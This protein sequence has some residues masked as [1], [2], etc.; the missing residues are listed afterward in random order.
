M[1]D[2]HYSGT[3]A[4][5]NAALAGSLKIHAK[6]TYSTTEKLGYVTG[7]FKIDDDDSRV[8][9]SFSGTIDDGRLVGYL[10]GKA[11]GNHAKVLGNLSADFAGGTTSFSN[12][13]VGSSSS[14]AVLAIVAG[15][16]CKMPKPEKEE[17][18]ERE[19]K[20]EKY[21]GARGEITALSADSITVTG[22]KGAVTCKVDASYAVPAGFSL[23][24][25]AVEMKCEA[26]G[27]PAVW[28]LRKLEKVS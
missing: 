17:K 15:P 12:G 9:G 3:V 4:S 23:A 20:A 25:T 11:R 7:S 19:K 27:D 21:I 24:S 13:L 28:T 5:T 18:G 2:G 8:R 14:D 26:V 10:T 1:T 6:T 16:A 22:K